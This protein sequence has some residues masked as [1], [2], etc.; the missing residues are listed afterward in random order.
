M[1]TFS[2]FQSLLIAL[3]PRLQLRVEVIPLF[4]ILLVLPRRRRRLPTFIPIE[5]PRVEIHTS[6]VR[7]VPIPV[8]HDPLDELDDLGNV[9]GDARDGVCG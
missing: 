3:L 4:L 1:G 7:G 9:L 5:Q 8:L 6:V 2:F